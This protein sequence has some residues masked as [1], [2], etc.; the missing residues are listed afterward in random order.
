MFPKQIKTADL[1]KSDLPGTTASPHEIIVFTHT[2][3]DESDYNS[4]LGLAPESRKK[5]VFYKRLESFRKKQK[6]HRLE[7]MTVNEIRTELLSLQR[8]LHHTNES[9]DDKYFRGLI[10]LIRQKL[11]R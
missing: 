7:E 9:Y 3:L 11:D 8:I 1:K 4:S 5:T 6:Q 10:N 2:F